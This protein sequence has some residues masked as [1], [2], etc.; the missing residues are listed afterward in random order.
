LSSA[1][2]SRKPYSTSTSLRRSG[3]RDTSRDLR[4]PVWMAPRHDDHAASGR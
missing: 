1:D 2:G 4:A 3:R